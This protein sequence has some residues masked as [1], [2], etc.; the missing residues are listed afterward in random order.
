MM[1]M[2]RKQQ[3]D[4]LLN[5]S[6]SLL[7]QAKAGDWMAVRDLQEQYRELAEVLFS[8]PVPETESATVAAV[9][10]DAIQANRQVLELGA[11][12]QHACLDEMGV[13]RQRRQ[14]VRAYTANQS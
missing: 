7:E 9:V 8:R 5:C 4:D 11:V 3:L 2:E 10:R 13:N 14:A 1:N 12:A 6:Y